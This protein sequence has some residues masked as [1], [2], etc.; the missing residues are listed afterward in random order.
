MWEEA[1]AAE[2]DPALWVSAMGRAYV[3]AKKADLRKP[4]RLAARRAR[5]AVTKAKSTRGRT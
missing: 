3:Q 5:V 1:L 2:P 4:L